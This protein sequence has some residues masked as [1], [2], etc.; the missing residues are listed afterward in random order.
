MSTLK[1]VKGGR[2]LLFDRLFDFEPDQIADSASAIALTLDDLRTSVTRELLRL[3]ATRCPVERRTSAGATVINYGIPD[4]S[5]VFAASVRQRR[6]LEKS[7][8]QAIAAFE[9]RLHAPRVELVPGTGAGRLTVRIEG[10]LRLGTV[11]EPLFFA[12]RLGAAPQA[13]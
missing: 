9:P 11:T 8:L 12:T 2:S 3:L 13:Q 7:I 5:G 4:V 6:D 10:E 1:T